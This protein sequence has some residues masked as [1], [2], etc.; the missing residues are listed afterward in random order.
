[1]QRILATRPPNLRKIQVRRNRICWVNV[2]THKHPVM[3]HL[4]HFRPAQVR[5]GL[6]IALFHILPKTLVSPLRLLVD[7]RHPSHRRQHQRRLRPQKPL[8]RPPVIIRTQRLTVHRQPP[9]PHLILKCRQNIVIPLPV[10]PIPLEP[11]RRH[12]HRPRPQKPVVHVNLPRQ[13]I[14]NRPRAKLP[15]L[16]PVHKLSHRLIPAPLQNRLIHCHTRVELPFPLARRAPI[17]LTHPRRTL[18]QQTSLPHQL[19]QTKPMPLIASPLMPNLQP[20]ARPPRRLH[21]PPRV[22]CRRRHR[23]LAIHMQPRLQTG[24]G[25]LRMAKVRR[26]NNHRVQPIPLLRQHLPIIPIPLHM[27]LPILRIPV[28]PPHR[29]P[30]LVLL[31]NVAHRP[32]PHR[33][34]ACQHRLHQH[35]PPV[36][37]PQQ[38]HP[39]RVLPLPRRLPPHHR[40]NRQPRPRRRRRPQKLPPRQPTTITLATHNQHPFPGKKSV[41]S[42]LPLYRVAGILPALRLL[43]AAGDTSPY[44]LS[45]IPY[46]SSRTSNSPAPNVNRRSAATASFTFNTVTAVSYPTS[47]GHVNAA[48]P[49]IA[50]KKLFK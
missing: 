29:R 31:P 25:L 7:R 2:S 30:Q 35:A 33:L 1:M 39:N 4:P 20:L 32:K 16:P 14:H 13:P 6:K 9:L 27:I 3:L 44:P 28:Q 47:A 49:R 41:T 11:A 24:N 42:I 18:P 37:R 45:L 38:R 17:P 12:R 10:P 8:K 36:P 26:R 22:L 15:E 34:L 46:P 19:L 5:T 50:A 48:L 23:P 43:V 21:H 40:R